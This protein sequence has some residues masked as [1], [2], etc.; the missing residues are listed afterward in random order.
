MGR[1]VLCIA[2]MTTMAL[3]LAG[4]GFADSHAVVP[5]FMRTKVGEVPLEPVPDVKQLVREHLDSVFTAASAPRDV[6]VS[7]ARHDL[8]GPGWTACVRAELTSATGSPL[9]VQTYRINIDNGVIFDRQRVEA[10]DTCLSE[11]FEPI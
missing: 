3:A 7:P 8:R 6:Q 2:S 1:I 4:C 10:E 11:S 9:G 5:D